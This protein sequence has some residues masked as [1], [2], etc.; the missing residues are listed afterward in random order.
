MGHYTGRCN[1]S[2]YDAQR[3]I[4]QRVRSFEEQGMTILHTREGVQLY[5]KMIKGL[6]D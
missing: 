1:L 4:R 6:T 2:A 5:T 3:I